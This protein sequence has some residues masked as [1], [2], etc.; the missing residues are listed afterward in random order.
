MIYDRQWFRDVRAK[1]DQANSLKATPPQ[2]AG[3]PVI[4]AVQQFDEWGMFAGVR[5]TPVYH[6]PD[7]ATGDPR[8]TLADTAPS[9]Y[10][11][12]YDYV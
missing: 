8:L 12:T 9:E 4:P 1:L 3:T 2:D 5:D 10:L 7:L 6:Q 11:S